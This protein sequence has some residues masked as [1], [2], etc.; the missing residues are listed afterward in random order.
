MKRN[1]R[2]TRKKIIY[3]HKN[4]KFLILTTLIIILLLIIPLTILSF[5]LKNLISINAFSTKNYENL[6]IQQPLEIQPGT[7][8]QYKEYKYSNNSGIILS[9]PK[10][11]HCTWQQDNWK[12]CEAI[13]EI[14]DQRQIKQ[15]L[16]SPTIELEFENNKNVK[17]I[18]IS[19]SDNFQIGSEKYTETINQQEK[20]EIRKKE[21]TFTTTNENKKTPIKRTNEIKEKTTIKEETKYYNTRKFYNFQKLPTN[22]PPIKKIKEKNTT[23]KIETNQTTPTI[24]EENVTKVNIAEENTNE[25]TQEEPPEQLSLPTEQ[26]TTEEPDF[27]NTTNQVPEENQT[28]HVT[29]FSILPE[30][31]IN[32]QKP[33]A[34]KVAFK[35]PKYETNSFD[36]TI[37]DQNFQAKL[38]PEISA[39]GTLETQGTYSLE[40]DIQAEETCFIITADDITL[41]CQGHTITYSSNGN[42]YAIYSSSNSTTIKNCKIL[43]GN[44]T[45]NKSAIYISGNNN[46]IEETT[47]ITYSDNQEG[48]YAGG[49]NNNLLSN[50]IT[51]HGRYAHPVYL[52]TSSNNLVEGNTL[53]TNYWDSYG[54]YLDSSYHNQL[55]RNNITA[56]DE[57]AYLIRLSNSNNNTIEENNLTDIG[58]LSY[59]LYIHSNS[60][61]NNI[62]NNFIFVHRGDGGAININSSNNNFLNN[63]IITHGTGAFGIEAFSQATNNNFQG[64][65][66]T[67]YGP[68]SY[69]LYLISSSDNNFS[70]NKLTTYGLGSFVITLSAANNNTFFKDRI[71]SYGE[72]AAGILMEGPTTKNSFSNINATTYNSG[73][74]IFYA[75]NQDHNFSVQ[76]SYIKT[77][78]ETEEVY[79]ESSLRQGTYNFTN[80]TPF[81][82]RW[83]IATSG[84]LIFSNYLNIFTNFTNNS[85]S[86]TDLTIHNS[87]GEEVF[88]GQTNNNGSLGI[89]LPDSVRTNYTNTIFYSNYTI[90][91]SLGN[92]LLNTSLNLSK[93]QDLYFTFNSTLYELYQDYS[94]P[95]INCI[96]CPHQGS[97]QA[98]QNIYIH[99]NSTSRISNLSTFIDLDN[100]L[101]GWWRMDDLN[102]RGDVVDYTGKNNGTLIG[103]TKQDSSG[104]LG[105]SLEFDGEGDCLN[106]GNQSNLHLRNTF[107]IVLWIKTLETSGAPT[108]IG[109]V[110]EGGVYSQY[111]YLGKKW[112]EGTL[113]AGLGD[114][115]KYS[116]IYSTSN[117][118]DGQW[119]QVI[120]VKEGDSQEIYVD[121]KL[122]TGISNIYSGIGDFNPGTNIYL[123]GDAESDD[124]W[125]NGSIDDLMI[126]NRK[127]TQEEII[128]LYSNQTNNK[129]EKN[130]TSLSEGEHTFKAYTQD[131]SAK[132]NTTDNIEFTIDSNYTPNILPNNPGG[133]GNSNKSCKPEW[134]CSIWG[135]CINGK[136]IRTCENLNEKCDKQR[137]EV[138]RSCKIKDVPEKDKKSKDIL[139]DINLDLIKNS[140]SPSEKLS[141]T[142]TLI[143]LGIPGKVLANL[144]YEIIN[145]KGE[146]VYSEE[147][148]VPVETQIEFIKTI[149]T[150][151]LE[152]GEYTLLADLK[153]ENQT[154]PAHSEEK[155]TIGK[156]TLNN[157]YGHSIV[158]IILLLIFAG[159]ILAFFNL[160]KQIRKKQTF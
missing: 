61:Y 129:L 100:T 59:P 114:G 140:L 86:I 154:E 143:N 98:N 13:F 151:N 57:E 65:N 107:S 3:F 141:G 64:N 108:I 16:S 5:S 116:S 51:T 125:F 134:N 14:Q 48:I 29:G 82:S 93:N 138:E 7:E 75:Y 144:T 152:E 70:E 60:N 28:N 56:S 18:Q 40:Q 137:P 89:I 87:K 23:Q 155:F 42:G 30:Q 63:T 103:D 158:A 17:N 146:I 15:I 11:I 19:Y 145:S 77:Y 128:S 159:I 130:F 112:E 96:D 115:S 35:I 6:Q 102:S 101:I 71:I 72:W 81:E 127:L 136:Q 122:D 12:Q 147:E 43:E 110:D 26:T 106:L 97:T 20:I 111:W 91:A 27:I 113:E 38:D 92:Q 52:I 157:T 94:F 99:I 153:Y 54:I 36:F 2:K 123:G 1:K 46:K 104:K 9:S 49:N 22:N 117:L 25:T 66:I 120:W 62:I 34:I 149:D 47:I 118:V 135:R 69:T 124:Y 150:S 32:T 126:F 156:S 55:I 41:D 148:T 80:V 79:L 133:G 142:I 160:I 39:C 84:N 73:S 95:N 37:K 131:S 139:F 88:S 50:N 44:S 58:Q 85:A 21:T 24:V 76:D 45:G 68:D 53:N 33:F 121:G 67:T 119:H 105:K 78:S 8:K 4:I 31:G 132:I 74:E 90:T 109:R 83:D 10:Q